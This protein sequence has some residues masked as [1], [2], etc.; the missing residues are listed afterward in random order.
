MITIEGNKLLALSV[1]VKNFKRYSVT[2]RASRFVL[3]KNNKQELAF[4]RKEKIDVNN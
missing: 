3:K 2:L 4:T 1:E